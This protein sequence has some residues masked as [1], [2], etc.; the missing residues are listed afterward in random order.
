M[1]SFETFFR[2]LVKDISVEL[3][4]E[5]DRNFER[6]G[7]FNESWKATKWANSKG[8]LMM[9]SGGL[10][11]SVKNQVSDDSISWTSSRPDAILHNNGGEITVTAKMK[12]FFWAMYYKA[13]GAAGKGKSKRAITLTQEAA[14]WKSLALMK[15]GS[16][17]KI[18]KRQ[19]IGSH[20]QVDKTIKEITDEHVN[21]LEASLYNA[22]K[23]RK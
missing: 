16:K 12:R 13:S 7:F 9:R 6:K 18:P 23:N 3:T 1:A 21:K 4:D 8:S 5:F 17:M 14:R 11:R 19:F 15:V 2:A 10:R 20:P 22:L